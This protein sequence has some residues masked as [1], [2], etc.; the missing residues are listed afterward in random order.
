MFF[1]SAPAGQREKTRVFLPISGPFFQGFL[2]FQRNER[3]QAGK[4][5]NFFLFRYFP[6]LRR[7]SGK[8]RPFS[9]IFPD[10]RFFLRA[11]DGSG[12]KRESGKIRPFFPT[13][14]PL[15]FQRNLRG[16]PFFRFACFSPSHRWLGKKN[17]RHA[18]AN[19]FMR[20][21][22]RAVNRKE[23][24]DFI[25]SAP[26]GQRKK[27]RES[28]KKDQEKGPSSAVENRLRFSTADGGSPPIPKDVF[29]E[30]FMARRKTSF[31]IGGDDGSLRAPIED[32]CPERSRKKKSWICLCPEG[33]K[34][35]PGSGPPQIAHNLRGPRSTIFLFQEEEKVSKSEERPSPQIPLESEGTRNRKDGRPLRFL[36]NLRGLR[37]QRFRKKIL[38][39]GARRKNKI[40]FFFFPSRGNLTVYA[41]SY[42]GLYL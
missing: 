27:K 2:P 13:P 20:F 34:T 38:E 35:N 28:G 18:P 11:I 8:T 7:S 1:F 23:R 3:K 9:D 22:R 40:F 4:R 36:W 10:S 5:A 15:R 6:R 14:G 32:R 29:P 21:A 25:P 30:P 26:Q 17:L 41:G 16:R 31:G 33:A 42:G 19:P 24:Q 39:I 37:N 12:K